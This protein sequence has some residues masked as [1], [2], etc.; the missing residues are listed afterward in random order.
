MALVTAAP[1]PTVTTILQQVP[2]NAVP[3]NASYNITVDPQ[4]IVNTTTV[5]NAIGQ[6]VTNA[7]Y[8]PYMRAL[9]IQFLG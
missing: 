7:A 3:P 9:P 5:S 4:I 2:N 8:I 1:D 6:A